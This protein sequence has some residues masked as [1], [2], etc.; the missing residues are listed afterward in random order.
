VPE[1]LSFRLSGTWGIRDG[2]TKNRCARQAQDP[3][4]IPPPCNQ[5]RIDKTRVVD[6]GI[7]HRTND[8]DAFAAR[9][10]L[11]YKVPMREGSMEWLANV[12]GGQNNS[13]AFQ[14][15]HRGVK[16]NAVTEKP[17]PNGIGT[18]DR[19]GYKDRDGDP[20]AGEYDIDGP[21]DIDVWGANLKGTWLFGDDDA[22]ELQSLTAYEWNDRYTL[23]NTD[24]G[25]KFGLQT[26]YENSASQ[27]SQQ[28][29]L[30][31]PIRPTKFGDGDWLLG[32]YFL[33]EDLD[34][35][36]FYQ[37]TGDADFR[38]KY[39]QDMWNFAPYA[40]VEYRLQPGCEPVSCDFTFL[41]GGRYNWEHKN[42]FTVVDNFPA[43]DNTIRT[44]IDDENDAL[45]RDW[46]GDISVAWNY[47][48]DSN[49]YFKF[50]RG[51]KGGHFNGGATSIF[52]II[53]GVDPE[54]VDS[55]EVGL[56]SA[57]FD[58]RLRLNLTGFYYDY[59][60][61]QVFVVEQTPLGFPIP[62]LANASEAFVYGVELDLQTEP[63]DGLYITFNA[64]WVESEYEDFVVS[65]TQRISLR[66]RGEPPPD[67][68]F[69]VVE[70]EFDYTGNTLIAS[71]NFSATGSIEYD[72]PLS[73]QL[74]GWSL[75]TLRGVRVPAGASAP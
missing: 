73:G 53:T 5:E 27:W 13:R 44:A 57:W 19:Y 18:R 35:S 59:L 25:P 4:P 11:L 39:N 41:L 16:L 37:Q 34:V 22:Y 72:I 33:E 71:P 66:Q 63:I 61:L 24:A 42:F 50:A 70:R 31:G 58:Q 75:G 49:L 65:F 30:R 1:V 14:Y 47:S 45:W 38:Q 28:L 43:S 60:D 55:Y 54:T 40:Q 20:F 10:Q 21:E 62:K 23:E 67:P 51:W 68:S 69:I 2:L 48:A 26:T 56:R 32:V 17:I 29:D 46:S 74:A 8:I 9:G 3:L 15:Q 52:D 6:P 36:N 7:D 64:A 12:H